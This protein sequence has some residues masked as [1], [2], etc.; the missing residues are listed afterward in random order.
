VTRSNTGRSGL[1]LLAMGAVL[2]LAACGTGQVSQTADTNT[3]VGGLNAELTA[4][5]GSYK[6]RNLEVPFKDDGYRAGETAP[7]EVTLFN[8]TGEA[9]TVRVSSDSAESVALFDSST[10]SASASVSVSASA[11]VGPGPSTGPNGALQ[12]PSA[13]PGTPLPDVTPT[14][15]PPA[16]SPANFEIP[17]G[18]YLILTRA[19]DRYLQLVGLDKP[20]NFGDTVA[21]TFDFGGKTLD[22]IVTMT[23]PLTP[24]PRPTVSVPGEEAAGGTGE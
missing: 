5:Q 20:L 19:A 8:D 22:T 18:G 21:M 9:V 6:V 10:P 13:G 12:T 15:L 24:L 4:D 17:A 7:V 2:A 3:A 14:S 11:S 23:P 16:G 1:A